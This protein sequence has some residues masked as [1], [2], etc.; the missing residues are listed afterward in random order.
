MF[1]GFSTVKG[2][3]SN[4]PMYTNGGQMAIPNYANGA[5]MLDVA[6]QAIIVEMK[7]KM[8]RNKCSF[9]VRVLCNYV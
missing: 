8:T 7:A 4:M 5:R 9:Y 6:L 1:R 2:K 3:C